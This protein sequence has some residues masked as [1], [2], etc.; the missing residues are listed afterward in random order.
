MFAM[1]C[2][3]CASK[4]VWLMCFV[5]VYAFMCVDFHMRQCARCLCVSYWFNFPL[6]VTVNECYLNKATEAHKCAR[7]EIVD[8]V[9][10]LLTFEVERADEQ[11]HRR[12]LKR[13]FSPSAV[14]SLK[15]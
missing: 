12:E 6:Y 14:I 7:V 11:R 9:K 8:L 15:V 10:F 2:D 13:N 3:V 1:P 4:S 5:A